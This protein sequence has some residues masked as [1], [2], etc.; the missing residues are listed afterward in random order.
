MTASCKQQQWKT[1]GVCVHRMGAA[2]EKHHAHNSVLDNNKFIDRSALHSTPHQTSSPTV[3]A[4]LVRLE[5]RSRLAEEPAV[6]VT[7]T[8]L[9]SPYTALLFNGLPCLPIVLELHRLRIGG[10]NLHLKHSR[11]LAVDVGVAAP[12]DAEFRNAAHDVLQRVLE[13]HG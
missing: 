9:V 12:R 11:K 13:G 1:K 6:Q 2:K 7:T 8:I 3:E 10:S 5:F 4:T